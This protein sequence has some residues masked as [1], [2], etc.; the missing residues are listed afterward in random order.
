MAPK[1]YGTGAIAVIER[2]R[3][4]SIQSVLEK[5]MIDI[6]A[7]GNK[8]YIPPHQKSR[9]GKFKARNRKG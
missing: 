7:H 4:V 3:T 2:R 1:P 8:D 6:T 9:R 5:M